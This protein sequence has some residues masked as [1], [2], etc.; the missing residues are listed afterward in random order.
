MKLQMNYFSFYLEYMYIQSY[1]PPPPPPPP[2]PKKKRE[3]GTAILIFSFHRYK[4]I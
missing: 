1:P 4:L 3:K 2:P